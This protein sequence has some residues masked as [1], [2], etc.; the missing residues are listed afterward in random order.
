MRNALSNARLGILALA[1]ACI[2]LPVLA[3]TTLTF[4]TSDAAI[5][6]PDAT[7]GT[8]TACQNVTVSAMPTTITD[9]T[10]Q[11]SAAHSWVGDLTVRL[12]SPGA[13]VLTLINRPGRL[14]TGFGNDDNLVAP[15]AIT[16]NDAAAS[17]TL[18]EDQGD[19][20]AGTIG[21]TG[22]CPDNYI[23]SPDA[24]DTPPGVGSNLAQYDGADPNGVWQLCISDAAGGDTGTLSSWSITVTSTPV[25]LQSFTIE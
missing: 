14:G 25:E 7:L 15:T 5:P 6:I 1:A 19:G 13:S 16:Y 4:T 10:V 21:V 23:P 2:V 17:A 9:V 20:C 8:F 11:V 18:A 12:T 24:G 22:G 3:G